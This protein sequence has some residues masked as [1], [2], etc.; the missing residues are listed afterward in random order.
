[1]TFHG[2]HLMAKCVSVSQCSWAW[3]MQWTRMG[4]QI[5]CMRGASDIAHLGPCCRTEASKGLYTILHDFVLWIYSKVYHLI[6]SGTISSH[7]LYYHLGPS[8]LILPSAPSEDN[9]SRHCNLL[10]LLKYVSISLNEIMR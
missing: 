6:W 9:L 10:L 7:N 2:T 4:I 5:P 3:H 1:M 8:F